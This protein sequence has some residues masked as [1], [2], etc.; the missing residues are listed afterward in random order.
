MSRTYHR[1][2]QQAQQPYYLYRQREC[3]TDTKILIGI[4]STNFEQ[5]HYVTASVRE[6][7]VVD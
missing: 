6:L 2:P 7:P 5:T 3:Q 4:V 1:C